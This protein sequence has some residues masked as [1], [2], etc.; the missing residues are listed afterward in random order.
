M[1]PCKDCITL[2]YCIAYLN[3][4]QSEFNKDDETMNLTGGEYNG[5][6]IWELFKKC[7]LLCDYIPSNLSGFASEPYFSIYRDPLSNINKAEWSYRYYSLIVFYND[8]W[9]ERV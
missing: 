3:Q 5:E 9:V 4:R 7:S 8:H 1:I 2:A 6:S